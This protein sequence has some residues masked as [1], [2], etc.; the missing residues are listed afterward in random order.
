MNWSSIMLVG[1][2]IIATMCYVVKARHEYVGP[3][4]H[5]KQAISR[6]R[7]GPVLSTR[8]YP[9]LLAVVGHFANY[10]G[11]DTNWKSRN[12]WRSYYMIFLHRK[13]VILGTC[14]LQQRQCWLS[15]IVDFGK[16]RGGR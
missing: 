14:S 6:L 12:W 4:M 16:S 10:E 5:V 15:A 13:N 8:I 3:V 9:N 11:P 1:V 7:G 2:L